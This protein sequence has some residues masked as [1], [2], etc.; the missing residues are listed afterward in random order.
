MADRTLQILPGG[1]SSAPYTYTVPASSEFDLLAVRAVFDG[2]SAGGPF[3]PAIQIFSDAGVLMAQTFA[4]SV[5]VGQTADATFAPFLET[6]APT[7]TGQFTYDQLI[8]ALNV[9][10]FYK[11]DE[12]TGS[13]AHDSSGNGHHLS[14]TST[15]PTWAQTLAP[16]GTVAPIFGA[17]QSFGNTGAT[18]TYSPNLTGD[19]SV[20]VWVNNTDNTTG[21]Y[22]FPV[23]QGDAQNFQGHG[24]AL[25]STHTNVFPSPYHLIL[26]GNGVNDAFRNSDNP[27]SFNAWYHQAIVHSG[28]TW[29]QYINGVAQASTYGGVYSSSVSNLVIGEGDNPNYYLSYALLFNYALT[30]TQVATLAGV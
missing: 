25:A 18:N 21:Q 17:H 8:L 11:L 23:W 12:T 30:A 29:T 27:F 16:S 7:G 2:T 19:F 15:T 10:A 9:N 6:V 28:S 20:C 24:W 1:Q 22:N 14:A 26:I 4:S 5:S 3:L 13:V